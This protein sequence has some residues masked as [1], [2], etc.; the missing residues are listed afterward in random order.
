MRERYP[1]SGGGCSRAAVGVNSLQSIQTEMP[2]LKESAGEE[3]SLTVDADDVT[4]DSVVIEVIADNPD[5]MSFSIGATPDW[6][7]QFMSLLYSTSEM[8]SVI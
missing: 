8:S 7:V 5:D 4:S 3:H 2:V 1:G 6:Q